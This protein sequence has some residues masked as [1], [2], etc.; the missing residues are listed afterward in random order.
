MGTRISRREFL[1]LCGLSTASLAF[2]PFL[3]NG[4]PPDDSDR[5]RVAIDSVS[6][7]REPS[8]KSEL[9]Y[10]RYRD[11][12]IH[13]Y[14]EVKSTHGPGY[15]PLWYRV[16]RGYLHS[17]HVV[18]VKTQLNPLPGSV[19]ESGQLTE[20]TV[21][22]TQSMRYTSYDGWTPLYRLYN[23][24][25]H[26]VIGI[27]EGPDGEP[28]YRIRDEL[29]K[30][31]IYFAPAP[32]LRPVLPE[33]FA[34]ISPEIPAEKKRIEVSITQQTLTAY[35]EDRIVLQT[36]ISSGLFYK[37]PGETSWKTPTGVFN[38]QS[39]MPSKHMGDGYL[40]ADL[41][42][43]EL[44]GVPWVC[45]FEMKN[46]IA[47]HGTYWHTNYGSTMSHGCVNMRSAEAKWLYRWTTPIAGPDDWERRG[48]GTQVIVS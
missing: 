10:T 32:H 1:K 19:P 4:N 37:P 25:T 38:I 34:P 20:V 39:K 21:P 3:R 47:T 22:Y 8:D 18:K 2:R 17:G 5:V 16:W 28:W 29:D 7:Y 13:V 42:A 11:E 33:E 35:E 24:S 31:Y 30:H 36:R 6:I 23:E 45:F 14:Y 41:N 9:L 44:P 46:G 43:Y 15:N 48:L 26:W 12:L 40:T 27:D